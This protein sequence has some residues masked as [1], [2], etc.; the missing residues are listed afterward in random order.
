MQKLKKVKGDS[1]CCGEVVFHY[2][3]FWGGSIF[4]CFTLLGRDKRVWGSPPLDSSAHFGRSA[5]EGS[6]LV[7]RE[8]RKASPSVFGQGVIRSSLEKWKHLPSFS[9][10]VIIPLLHRSEFIFS[11]VHLAHIEFLTTFQHF[12]EPRVCQAHCSRAPERRGRKHSPPAEIPAVP[13]LQQ[14][15]PQVIFSLHTVFVIHVFIR[16]TPRG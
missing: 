10:G 8:G 3:D 9:V 15:L 2:K 13:S 14:P 11:F 12:F 6:V 5:S 1:M 7:F 16:A 4:L